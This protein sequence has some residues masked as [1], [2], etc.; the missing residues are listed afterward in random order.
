M[1][2]DLEL[3]KEAAGLLGIHMTGQEWS[4]R[5]GCDIP[6]SGVSDIPGLL[7][8]SGPASVIASTNADQAVLI[9][10]SIPSP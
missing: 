1:D 9:P 6:P 10:L 8:T 4:V 7:R 3:G 5:T 2:G